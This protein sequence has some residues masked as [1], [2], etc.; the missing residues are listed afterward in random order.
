MQSWR[1]RWV[2]HRTKLDQ[3]SQMSHINPI[4]ADTSAQSHSTLPDTLRPDQ[5]RRK[6]PVQAAQTTHDR[7][8]SNSLLK[9]DEILAR[10]LKRM[11]PDQIEIAAKYQRR[12]NV[13]VAQE[14]HSL[15]QGQIHQHQK[16]KS[17]L[18]D[19]GLYPS[20]QIQDAKDT[21]EREF[22][23]SHKPRNTTVAGRTDISGSNHI[24]KA[25]PPR[26]SNSG[27]EMVG[28]RST[29]H[30]LTA[31]PKSSDTKHNSSSLS[32]VQTITKT[33]KDSPV[34]SQTRPNG[35]VHVSIETEDKLTSEMRAKLALNDDDNTDLRSDISDIDQDEILIIDI[36][37]DLLRNF[38]TSDEALINDSSSLIANAKIIRSLSQADFDIA[39][40]NWWRTNPQRTEDEWIQLFNQFCNPFSKA[41][42]QRFLRVYRKRVQDI[43]AY[44]YTQADLA[45]P[46]GA[47]QDR[48]TPVRASR[49]PLSM[50]P[51]SGSK[52]Q[53]PS[54][55]ETSTTLSD[56]KHRRLIREPSPELGSQ[57]YKRRTLEASPELGS[58]RKRR[59]LT[60]ESQDRAITSRYALD[61][62]EIPES[63]RLEETTPSTPSKQFRVGHPISLASTK[64]QDVFTSPKIL[65]TRNAHARLIIDESEDENDFASAGQQ[66]L[67]PPETTWPALSPPTT[68]STTTI[69]DSASSHNSITSRR[70]FRV[71][72]ESLGEPHV[73]SSID[74][75]LLSEEAEAQEAQEIHVESKISERFKLR[76]V[77]NKPSARDDIQS[78]PP[79]VEKLSR[80]QPTSNNLDQRDE[81]EESL[82]VSDGSG[83]DT[84][85]KSESTN[86]HQASRRSLPFHEGDESDPR[87][88]FGDLE[89]QIHIGR[90]FPPAVQVNRV[91]TDLFKEKKAQPNSSA[92]CD[93]EGGFTSQ[94]ELQDTAEWLVM[95]RAKGHDDKLLAMILNAA[96]MQVSV[97]G[98]TLR[99]YLQHNKLP[100]TKRGV[101]TAEDDAMLVQHS[102]KANRMLIKKHGVAALQQRKVHLETLRQ[103]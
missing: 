6:E 12:S 88:K 4:H 21:A 38:G 43:Y 13:E 87:P 11:T 85:L 81:I 10:T 40:N 42:E 50:S 45:T 70:R 8:V 62:L 78:S 73:Q 71:R 80:L 100:G 32:N 53:F 93:T 90:K 7:N 37:K 68:T 46:D 75:Q 92:E 27:P 34:P 20:P 63:P 25:D 47:R 64:M 9:S 16:E 69:S 102:R 51:G 74:R 39:W 5:P 31:N 60:P 98:T 28:G 23:A 94:D 1:D 96:T 101:W 24:S 65:V 26:T 83:E 97:A 66:Q 86:D 59:N 95:Q 33:R 36:W 15:L 91:A 79:T 55:Y 35:N 49:S 3:V 61:P 72:S 56:G 41:Y 67:I 103:R 30:N 44:N 22:S 18:P 77:T 58:R 14:Y 57:E 54:V 89:T 29:S 48:V 84:A 76:V 82:F 52:R 19:V 2:R 99:Y 17:N